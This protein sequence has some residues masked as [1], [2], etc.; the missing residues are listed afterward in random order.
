[1]T[2][3][4]PDGRTET[5]TG[6]LAAIVGARHVTT[7]ADELR[8][9]LRDVL[10]LYRTAPLC[11]VAPATT[12]EVAQVV[13]LCA[14]HGVPVVPMGGNTGL[15]GGA[16]AQPD[17]RCV[18]LSLRRMRRIREIAP[19]GQSITV[20]AGCILAE[21]QQ[22]AAE[23]GR[24]F[25]LSLTSE[26]S[27]QIGGAIST[28]AGGVN[29]LRY[30]VMRDLVLGLEVVLPDGQILDMN[31][32][33]FKDNAGL[34][35]KQLFIGANGTLGVVTG[36]VLKLFPAHR[37]GAT[38]MAG[39]GSIGDALALMQHLQERFGTRLTSL[40]LIDE[41]T[42]ALVHQHIPG[43]RLP[44]DRLC[45]WQLLIELADVDP[46][47]LLSEALEE[48][49][50]GA[51]EAGLVRD[52]MIARSQAQSAALWKL[53]HDTSEVMRHCGPRFASDIS[54]PVDAQEDFV[55]TLRARIGSQWPELT[56]LVFGHIGDGNLHVMV[57]CPG[58]AAP[59]PGE[60]Q[61]TRAAAEAVIDEIL[62]AMGGSVTAEHGIGLSYRHRLARSRS[63]LEVGLMSAVKRAL[64]PG[65]LMNPGKIYPD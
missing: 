41:A 44:F 49:L 24:L 28:N 59:A 11:M 43:S 7:D 4:A 57:C 17:G 65:N 34:D 25:P 31:R 62:I 5:L 1:M 37:A 53:R 52:A 39:L 36:A 48:A 12:Q 61:A 55:T 54:V 13:R 60:W 10:G 14:A 18:T 50:A 56:I 21:V 33:L 26:G 16:V 51:F 58:P 47:A 64:D 23:R 15:A 38:A 42:L 19:T 46:S 29:A 45:P 8:Q 20:D 63:P 2:T 22:A 9:S 27:C 6:A 30:G 40:E 35:L 32:R 3:S